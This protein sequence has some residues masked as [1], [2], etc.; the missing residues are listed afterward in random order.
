MKVGYVR[1]LNATPEVVAHA[2][3]DAIDEVRVFGALHTRAQLRFSALQRV[4][5][6]RSALLRAS[7]DT[8]G[9]SAQ[10]TCSGAHSAS[11]FGL[12]ATTLASVEIMGVETP[13]AAKLPTSGAASTARA[14]LDALGRCAA[15]CACAFSPFPTLLLRQ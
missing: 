10:R 4:H 9:L 3:G 1:P 6:V 12:Y 14:V 5:H 13:A 2:G 15:A 8:A 11:Y 7:Q